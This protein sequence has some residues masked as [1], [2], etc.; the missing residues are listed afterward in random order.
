MSEFSCPRDRTAS[1]SSPGVW[2]K[3]FDEAVSLP[4]GFDIAGYLTGFSLLPFFNSLA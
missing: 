3:P 2:L 1:G 4:Q